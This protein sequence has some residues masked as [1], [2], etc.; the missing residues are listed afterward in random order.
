MCVNDNDDIDYVEND[1]WWTLFMGWWT[2]HLSHSHT[3]KEYYSCFGNLALM[4]SLLC[5]NNENEFL[6]F[7]VGSWNAGWNIEKLCGTQKHGVGSQN[8]G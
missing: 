6:N 5:K 8:I 4:C 3:E 1:K 2:Y 7:W